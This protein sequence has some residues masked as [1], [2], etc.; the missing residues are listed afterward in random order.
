MINNLSIEEKI[1][2][3]NEDTLQELKK[4]STSICPTC[5]YAIILTVRVIGCV[6]IYCT[7]VDIPRNI[8]LDPVISCSE[9]KTKEEEKNE[10]KA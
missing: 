8:S 6:S 5:S 2:I 1:K 7:I 4:V 3:R 9:Y 10:A